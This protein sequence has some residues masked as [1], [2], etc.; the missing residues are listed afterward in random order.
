MRVGLGPAVG[1]KFDRAGF[2][3]RGGR[4]DL[5]I[6]EEPLFAQIGFDGNIGALA[7]ADVVGVV[8]HLDEESGFLELFDHRFPAFKPVESGKVFAGF[9][10]HDSI[11][12]DDHR[13]RKFVAQR[14]LVVGEVVRG[15]DFHTAGAKLRVDG[16]IGNDRNLF[17]AEWQN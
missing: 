11:G 17:I 15:G 6:P 1:I 12:A 3:G 14:H 5:G 8:L 7:I 13:E 9:R 2:D 10:R 4:R 16:G